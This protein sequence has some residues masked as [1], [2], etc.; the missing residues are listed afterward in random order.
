[1][2]PR[3]VRKRH[4]S[5]VL[6]AKLLVFFSRPAFTKARGTA[7]GAPLSKCW[8]T[9]PRRASADARFDTPLDHFYER[10]RPPFDDL[11]LNAKEGVF[12][13]MAKPRALKLVPISDC[14]PSRVRVRPLNGPGE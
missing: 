11:V 6:T 5:A 7:L 4:T 10:G 2:R 14:P 13:V 1:M 3:D 9:K 8:P 12:A